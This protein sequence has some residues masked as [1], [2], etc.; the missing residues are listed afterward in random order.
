MPILEIKDLTVRYGSR[1]G[2]IVA[3]ADTAAFLKEQGR[4]TDV[5][6]DFGR[7]VTDAYVKAAMGK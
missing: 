1:D 7:F 6:A 3:L 5:P 2:V 4:V